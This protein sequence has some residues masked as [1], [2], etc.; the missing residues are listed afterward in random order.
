ML[1]GLTSTCRISQK[2]QGIPSIEFDC[3]L[4]ILEQAFIHSKI[5]ILSDR[6]PLGNDF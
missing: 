5:N 2:I 4:T 1:K 6:E 3:T